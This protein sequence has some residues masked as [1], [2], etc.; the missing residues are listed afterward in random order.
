MTD[1]LIDDIRSELDNGNIHKKYD[2][3]INAN[4]L[5]EL[6]LLLYLHL[7][8]HV[9]FLTIH[10]YLIFPLF[11]IHISTLFIYIFWHYL[12]T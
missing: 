9:L 12:F 8:L 7:L 3:G 2:L 1:R 11:S 5:Q 10:L 6:Y 4:S